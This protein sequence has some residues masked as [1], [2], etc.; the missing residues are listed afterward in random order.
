MLFEIPLAV[1]AIF[2]EIQLVSEVV[3]LGRAL[4]FSLAFFFG[5]LFLLAVAAVSKH[6]QGIK[7]IMKA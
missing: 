6:R 4:I 5:S 1:S 7:I 3:S 2:A